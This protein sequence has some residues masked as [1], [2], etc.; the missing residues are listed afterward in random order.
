MTKRPRKPGRKEFRE[1]GVGL[2]IILALFALLLGR[3]EAP[4]APYLFGAG[5]LSLTFAWVIPAALGPIY[6][7][8][9]KGAMALGAVNAFILTTLIYYLV[10]T[11]YAIVA[12]L[13]GKDLLDERLRTG[14]SYWKPRD[15]A[16][17]PRRQF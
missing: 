11:P 13:M 9:M 8:W 17:D 5:A 4:V 2:G 7:V 6:T 16:S 1:F 10:I 15:G 12:R 14:E 3:K